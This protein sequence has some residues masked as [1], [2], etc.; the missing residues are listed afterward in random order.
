MEELG[1]ILPWAGGLF[2]T[3]LLAAFGYT[4]KRISEVTY[5]V[6]HDIEEQGRELRRD[7]SVITQAAEARAQEGRTDRNMIWG[8]IEAIQAQ[9]QEQHARMLER[10]GNIATR[11]EVRQE[12]QAMEQRLQASFR[13][14]PTT[15]Q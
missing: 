2:V 9:V 10:L 4:H 5:D 11:D 3:V 1:G 13:A 8:R 6:R 14:G 15:R 7:L 12:L